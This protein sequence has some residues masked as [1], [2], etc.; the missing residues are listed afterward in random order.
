VRPAHHKKGIATLLW[1]KALEICLK[2]SKKRKFSV[3]SSEYAF[4]VYKIWGFKRTN[5]KKIKNGIEYIPMD[6]YLGS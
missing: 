5:G 2:K 6:M 1:K 3:N 4:S